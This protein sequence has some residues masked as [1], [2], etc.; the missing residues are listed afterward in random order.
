MNHN[1]YDETGMEC[2]RN[3]AVLFSR[4][5]ALC[6]TSELQHFKFHMLHGSTETLHPGRSRL[7][8]LLIA[9]NPE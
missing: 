6:G 7:L 1:F 3:G 9:D 4:L 5:P 8:S 2:R